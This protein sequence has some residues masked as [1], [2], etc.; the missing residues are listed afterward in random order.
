MAFPWLTNGVDPNHLSGMILQVKAYP[1]WGKKWLNSFVGF[2]SKATQFLKRLGFHL[3]S[4]IFEG[5]LLLD[6]RGSNLFRN[7]RDSALFSCD[8]IEVQIAQKKACLT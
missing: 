7:F 8:S 2:I 5:S 3:P 6:F 4:I 1:T